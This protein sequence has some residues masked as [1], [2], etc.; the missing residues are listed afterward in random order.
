MR[1]A[2]QELEYEGVIY[3]RQGKGSFV[4]EPKLHERLVQRLTGF[5]QDV[6]NQGHAI[7]NRVL[8]LEVTIVDDEA[9][10]AL[11]L[12][13]N[14]SVI[15]LERLRFSQQSACESFTQLHS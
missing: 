12:D 3:R 14:E 5:H 4:A 9:I 2:L 10:I 11:G 6:V 8:R 1:R 7:A 15:A 13:A